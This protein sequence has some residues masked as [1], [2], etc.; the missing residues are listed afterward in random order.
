MGTDSVPRPAGNCG[1]AADRSDELWLC[2]DG[3]LARGSTALLDEED[4]DDVDALREAIG[5]TQEVLRT[6]L[7]SGFAS[8]CPRN[9]QRQAA[10]QKHTELRSLEYLHTLVEQDHRGI[11]PRTRPMLGF[12]NLA[13]DAT[14]IA[15]IEL[16]QRIHKD[17]FALTRLRLKNRA[18]PALERNAD[19]IDLRNTAGSLLHD[20]V[21][22][23]HPSPSHSAQAV[24][25]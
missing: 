21:W 13:S 15:S 23:L 24:H 4:R 16:L 20:S 22:Y 9:V 3:S 10:A 14:T 2:R 18:V 5:V 7:L 12:E 25:R 17:R 8:C 1:G 19:C 6:Q 11:K